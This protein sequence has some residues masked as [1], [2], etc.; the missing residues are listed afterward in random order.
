MKRNA[1]ISGLRNPNRSYSFTINNVELSETNISS[2]IKIVSALTPRE[3][4]FLGFYK[5]DGFYL[6]KSEHRKYKKEIFEF[7]KNNGNYTELIERQSE[8]I[9]LLKS[10]RE[11]IGCKISVDI[12]TNSFSDIFKKI[13]LSYLETIIFCPNIDWDE[14]IQSYKNYTSINVTD[15][16][17]KGYT[18]F[19]FSYT[20]SSDFSIT[21][22]PN[23][24]D[25]LLVRKLIETYW[26]I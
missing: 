18:D 17:I 22:N 1:T 20:D 19:L 7:F 2:L 15:Y 10:D 23:L 12:N 8:H 26:T 16:V 6:S 21:F 24:Y 4:L 13:C 9:S 5:S 25:I 3:E 14:F 11:L